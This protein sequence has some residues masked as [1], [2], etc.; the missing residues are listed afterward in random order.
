MKPSEIQVGKT[1]RN[2]GAGRTTRTVL[3]IGV[4]HNPGDN[5]R[6]HGLRGVLFEQPGREGQHKLIIDHFASWAGSEVK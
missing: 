5:F 1:Y 3:A 4:E 2:K 6:H